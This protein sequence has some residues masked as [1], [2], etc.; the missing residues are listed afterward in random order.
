MVK[1]IFNQIYQLEKYFLPAGRIL[2]GV[3]FLVMGVQQLIALEA[4]TGYVASAGLP[5][6]G[7]MAVLAGLFEVLAGSALISDFYTKRAA[8]LL[9][10]FVIL[11]TIIFHNPSYWA[12]DPT[13]QI[14]VLKNA[15]ILGGLL[16]VIAGTKE[17]S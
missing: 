2:I 10:G 16:F 12:M 15:A 11:V 6:P 4:V 14:M 9:A 5:I 8:T 17:Q 3:C 7:T 13:G 1:R